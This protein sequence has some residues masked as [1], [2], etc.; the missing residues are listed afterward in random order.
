MIAVYQLKGGHF[1][2]HV[3]YDEKTDVPIAICKFHPLYT[4]DQPVLLA[5]N[6]FVQSRNIPEY[7]MYVHECENLH[8]FVVCTTC[9]GNC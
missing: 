7:V 4:L 8:P 2:H 3:L 5:F 9:C 1:S 6:C